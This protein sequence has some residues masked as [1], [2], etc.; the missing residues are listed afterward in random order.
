MVTKLFPTF[1]LIFCDIFS[2][3]E[4]RV[5]KQFERLSN[6]KRDGDDLVVTF[7][8]GEQLKFDPQG[9]PGPASKEKIHWMR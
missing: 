8:S 7:G 2:E 9:R 5:F 1:S 6:I 3:V 4:K